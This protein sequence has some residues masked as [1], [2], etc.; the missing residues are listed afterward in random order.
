MRREGEG[1]CS[2]F[3]QEVFTGESVTIAEETAHVH[4]F[5]EMMYLLVDLCFPVN[6]STGIARHQIG[7]HKAEQTHLIG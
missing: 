2:R 5:D 4:G 1:I 6:H 3:C 7:P